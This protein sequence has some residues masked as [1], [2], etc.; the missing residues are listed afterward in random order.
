MTGIVS[1]CVFD[2]A[3]TEVQCIVPVL[4]VCIRAEA[5]SSVGSASLAQLTVERTVEKTSI[6]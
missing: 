1:L 2:T 6:R 4:F 3:V 5:S